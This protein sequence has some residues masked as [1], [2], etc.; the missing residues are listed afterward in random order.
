MRGLGGVGVLGRR[1][2]RGAFRERRNVHVCRSR[3]PLGGAPVLQGV[4]HALGGAGPQAGEHLG[5]AEPDPSL[6]DR[7]GGPGQG[8][9]SLGEFHLR[10][11]CSRAGASG[12]APDH[13]VARRTDKPLS[14]AASPPTPHLRRRS[15]PRSYGRPRRR[16]LTT[17][18]GTEPRLR[19]AARLT[20]DATVRRRTRD[21]EEAV[22][23][24]ARREPRSTG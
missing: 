17:E 13:T 19:R 21:S 9:Q 11:G 10:A 7:S 16:Y 18:S 3:Q 5:A 14:P 24:K 4:A 2:G 15:G 8:V 23:R 22:G 12:A 1:P 20:S 6:L